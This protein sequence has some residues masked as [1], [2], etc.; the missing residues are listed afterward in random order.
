MKKYIKIKIEKHIRGNPGRFTDHGW[1]VFLLQITDQSHR[2]DKFSDKIISTKKNIKDEL[3]ITPS[4][5]LISRGSPAFITPSRVQ[6][7]GLYIPDNKP[8]LFT[9]GTGE[10]SDDIDVLIPVQ[11]INDVIMGIND[12]NKRNESPE[13]KYDLPGSVSIS[14]PENLFIWKE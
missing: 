4:C 14:L 13:I 11:Y 6:D 2:G 7:Y 1:D 8:I 12:Y 10:N 5:T 3:F 9:R